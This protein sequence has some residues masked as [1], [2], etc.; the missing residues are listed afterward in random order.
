LGYRAPQQLSVGFEDPRLAPGMGFRCTAT[1][2]TPTMPQFL[3]KR[4]ADTKAFRHLALRRVV[5]LQRV[6]NAFT[7]IGGVWFHTL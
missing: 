4:E 7:Q 3:H 2:V 5:G 1:A 6:E